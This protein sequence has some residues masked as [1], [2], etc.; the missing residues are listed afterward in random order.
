MTHIYIAQLCQPEYSLPIAASDTFNG[1][2][3]AV[4][5]YYGPE[6][7]R[8]VWF[9]NNSKYFEN[10]QGHILYGGTSTI[11]STTVIVLKVQFI[12]SV[13]IITPYKLW[14]FNNHLK[15]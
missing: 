12:V 10:Y 2:L 11:P 4:D 5:D 14:C 6:N 15:A 3:D 13:G 7:K 9:P 8:G 1:L